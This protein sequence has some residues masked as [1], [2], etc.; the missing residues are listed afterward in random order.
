MATLADELN[1]PAEADVPI[2]I[3]LWVWTP[4]REQLLWSCLAAVIDSDTR[5][6][7]RAAHGGDPYSLNFYNVLTGPVRH[8]GT[9]GS[10]W[11]WPSIWQSTAAVS[12]AGRW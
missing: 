4:E 2:E 10:A 7:P 6:K 3:A 12:C 11:R 1:L 9:M 5:H 8:D